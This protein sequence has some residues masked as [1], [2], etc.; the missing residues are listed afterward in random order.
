MHTPGRGKFFNQDWV[1]VAIVFNNIPSSSLITKLEKKGVKF[2]RLNGRILHTKK[3]YGAELPWS[4]L[5]ELENQVE[6]LQIDPVWYP[7][8]LPT[9]DISVPE[10]EA[11][12]TW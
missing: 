1:K 2:N 9:L 12:R 5:N 8:E 3:V 6:I 10:I 4:L 11:D 7:K